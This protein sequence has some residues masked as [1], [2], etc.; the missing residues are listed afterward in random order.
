MVIPNAI[1]EAAPL[2]RGTLSSGESR[3]RSRQLEEPFDADRLDAQEGNHR[4][5]RGV[6]LHHCVYFA[7]FILRPPLQEARKRI[8][9]KALR[10][11]GGRPHA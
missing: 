11:D 7:K 6:M 4:M 1:L 3:K 5:A 2:P 10:S 9:E 8:S